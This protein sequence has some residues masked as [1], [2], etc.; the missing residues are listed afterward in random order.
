MPSACNS[1]T[2]P[3]LSR[4]QLSFS[5]T[6]I[7]TPRR[8]ERTHSGLPG[9]HRD[10][11]LPSSRRRLAA[12][13]SV[14]PLSTSGPLHSVAVAQAYGAPECPPDNRCATAM[15]E[16]YQ[17]DRPAETTPRERRPRRVPPG[18]N[19]ALCGQRNDAMCAELAR[20]AHCASSWRSAFMAAGAG[21][22]HAD[23]TTIRQLRVL[24]WL[25]TS[26]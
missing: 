5:H 4:G 18:R 8:G 9:R 20:D 12:P 16:G 25:Q 17:L 26:Y 15:T 19:A 6:H 10:F 22:K 23:M 3:A 13:W 1:G 24:I 2:R 11:V 21:T 14:G 7:G